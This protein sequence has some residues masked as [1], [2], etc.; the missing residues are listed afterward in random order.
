[1][2]A[3]RRWKGHLPPKRSPEGS[4]TWVHFVF[5]WWAWLNGALYHDLHGHNDVRTRVFT[6]L[7]MFTV[8]AMA[9]F[10][11]DALGESSAGFALSFV[12][13]QLILTFLWWRTGVHDPD[14]RPLSRPYSAVFML[15]TILVLISAF[16]PLPWRVTLWA[17]ALL[18]SVL[19]PLILF[20]L[21]RNNPVVQAQVD[22]MLVI[23]PS[24]V[25]RFGLFAIIVLGEVVVGVVQGVA[26]HNDLTWTVGVAAT[27]SM[28][29]AIGLW[30]IY[31]DFVS[32]R[33]PLANRFAVSGWLYAHLFMTMGI[34]ATGA[35][36]SNV[37]ELAGEPLSGEV[38]WL[39]VGAV[40]LAFT[41]VAVIMRMIQLP[42]RYQPLYRTGRTITLASG[43]AIL[44]LGFT[45]LSTIPLLITLI[46]F[47][48]TPIIYGFKVWIEVLGAEEMT[49]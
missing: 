12:A 45:R 39:L 43:L 26:A 31:F 14:H 22:R 38:R 8:A 49:I 37:V 17:I 4:K 42:E 33:T 48:L 35:A 46:V 19:L 40:A 9:A 32:L 29:A 13:Y 36:V 25:E 23:S 16:A 5:V 3:T 34:A 1:M 44:L 6:F 10:A 28:L 15:T 24:A 11:H 30:W 47:M 41:C 27:L 21:G 2:C 7:Q 20:N 18:L